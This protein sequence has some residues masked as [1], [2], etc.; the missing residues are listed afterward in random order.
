MARAGARAAL[1]LVANPRPRA[2]RRGRVACVLPARAR[3]P[4]AAGRMPRRG[5]PASALLM[6]FPR[7]QALLASVSATTTTGYDA[8]VR[9][10][11]RDRG[12]AGARGCS[13]CPPPAPRAPRG[14]PLR[15]SPRHAGQAVYS[16]GTLARARRSNLALRGGG[17]SL[18]KPGSL[19]A[20]AKTGTQVPDWYKGSIPNGNVANLLVLR[21]LPP[22]VAVA[23]CDCR[24]A[25][26]WAAVLHRRALMLTGVLLCARYHAY[27]A[28]LSSRA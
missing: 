12:N 19:Q 10:C 7:S 24:S 1:H 8:P 21:T 3:A 2:A 5:R 14:L 11:A 16:S 28:T 22:P 13:T 18:A 23:G 17:F 6:I 4:R 25:V 15:R 20:A 26:A 9:V 27:R